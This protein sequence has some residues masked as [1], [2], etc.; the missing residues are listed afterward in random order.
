M[1]QP[2]NRRFTPEVGMALAT[3]NGQRIGNAAIIAKEESEHGTLYV[4]TTDFGNMMRLTENEVYE[5][6]EVAN[7]WRIQKENSESLYRHYLTGYNDPVK[8]I[9][10]QMALLQEALFCL[11]E[12]L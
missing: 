10:E 11:K 3:R 1:P 8:R 12:K 9:H 7:W 6:F 4:T 2:I 5:L